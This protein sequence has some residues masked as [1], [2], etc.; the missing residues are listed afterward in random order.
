MH[1]RVRP[2]GP[3]ERPAGRTPSR[4]WPSREV[5]RASARQLPLAGCTGVKQ[6]MHNCTGGCTNQSLKG[7]VA[8]VPL[9]CCRA[10]ELK[11]GC[12]SNPIRCTALGALVGERDGCLKER[13]AG[14]ACGLLQAWLSGGPARV[15]QGRRAGGHAAREPEGGQG[16][17]LSPDSLCVSSGTSSWRTLIRG[18]A[19]YQRHF[20]VENT[21][22]WST[23]A[24]L[25]G[26]ST[27][28]T[29][30]DGTGACVEQMDM[31]AIG[32]QMDMAA[33]GQQ[34]TSYQ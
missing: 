19:T 24:L 26:A 9:W 22:S 3:V 23:A 28:A 17:S 6:H 16:T 10:C 25:R 14:N 4:G 27:W 31:A 29:E 18:A 5:P 11:D 2:D 34:W 30:V 20:F 32:Q 33:I 13:G 7:G 21:H 8:C 12:I 1:R 15:R